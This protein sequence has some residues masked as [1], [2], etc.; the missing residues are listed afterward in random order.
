VEFFEDRGR[1][2]H[3]LNK[4]NY[5]AVVHQHR[6]WLI[7]VLLEIRP[8]VVVTFGPD[9]FTGHPTH[10]MVG[11]LTTQAVANTSI[12]SVLY[13]IAVAPEQ[14]EA[15]FAWMDSQVEIM[16]AFSIET[17]KKPSLGPA[18][19]MLVA[20]P[21]E[22]ITTCVPVAHVLDTRRTAWRCHETQGGGG[23]IL[24]AFSVLEEECYERVLIKGEHADPDPL[25]G[26]LAA[27]A[28]ARKG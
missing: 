18:R 20:T 15:I 22:C 6:R 7:D 4:T 28:H 1:Q 3:H 13:Y 14:V 21:S 27:T 25:M 23:N 26:W 9:G 10:T 19:P 16:A 17:T 24:D 11:H 12:D 5:A 8:Q 2:S